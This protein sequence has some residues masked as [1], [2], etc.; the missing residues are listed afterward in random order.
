MPRLTPDEILRLRTIRPT[1]VEKLDCP[2]CGK[3][4]HLQVGRYGR[5]Y[6]C[7][8]YKITGCKGGVSADFHGRPIA[9]PGPSRIK[10]LRRAIMKHLESMPEADR[11]RIWHEASL[12]LWGEHRY[13]GRIT[14]AECRAVMAHLGIEVPRKPS[15]WERL[16]EDKFSLSPVSD[17]D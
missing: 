13:V 6:G 2:D 9:D 8:Q 12:S 11:Q 3:S 14:E 7:S 15:I 4:L 10:V 16:R 17:D 5:F 1:H